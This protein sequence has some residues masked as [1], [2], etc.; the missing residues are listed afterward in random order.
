VGVAGVGL[1]SDHILYTARWWIPAVLVLGCLK[2]KEIKEAYTSQIF[3]VLIIL[4]GGC[5]VPVY[6]RGGQAN[7][8]LK[9]AKCKS[10]NSW[11]YS[12]IAN[13]RIS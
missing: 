2:A 11:A 12:A 9:S 8:F 1:F 10:A 3:F 5:L 6:S 13:M 4:R 7:F